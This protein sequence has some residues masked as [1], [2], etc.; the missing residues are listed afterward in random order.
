MIT[1]KGTVMKYS[2]DRYSMKFPLPPN[3]FAMKKEQ[4]D[5]EEISFI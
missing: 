4:D 1:P 2:K 5:E 3:T